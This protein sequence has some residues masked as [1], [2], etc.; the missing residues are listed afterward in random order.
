[1]AKS[2]YQ[3]TK[4]TVD[5]STGEITSEE[6]TNVIRIPSEPA[7]IKLYLEDISRLYKLPSGTDKL[8]LELIKRMNYEGKIYVNAGLKKEIMSEL[9][10]TNIRS[11]N[12]NLSKFCKADVLA[13]V[14][15]G[16]YMA[17]PNL[18]GKGSWADIQKLRNAWIKLSY[19]KDGEKV[20]RTSLGLEK[21]EEQQ[22][23][24]K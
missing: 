9:G 16:T 8:L 10:I 22:R 18:F 5:H 2:V 24:F 12:N 15:Q 19:T 23:L 14:G 13:R 11:I 6:N 17:N 4:Q 3:E 21:E 7:F 20:I 1:M